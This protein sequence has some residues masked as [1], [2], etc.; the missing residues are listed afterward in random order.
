MRYEVSIFL[1]VVEQ[2]SRNG[3]PSKRELAVDHAELHGQHK[4]LLESAIE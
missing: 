2:L 1:T 3:I 4:K